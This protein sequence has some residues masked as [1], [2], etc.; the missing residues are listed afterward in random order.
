[1][2]A[3]P[4][5][6]K[7]L[8]DGFAEQRES[9]VLRTDMEVGP[10]RQTVVRSRVMKRRTVRIYLSSK[11]DYLNFQSW[12]STTIR[13]G[14]DW[15]DWTDPVDGVT[16]SARFTGNFSA[17][18]LADKNGPWVVSGLTIEVWGS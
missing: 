13:E 16:K 5:Y 4:S 10:P 8:L 18:P 15:F 2:A 11:T 12:Y 6:A 1:V 17:S 9:A 7:L 3:F 14:S